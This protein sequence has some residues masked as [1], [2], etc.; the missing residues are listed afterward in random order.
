[1]PTYDYRCTKC[2]HTFEAFQSMKDEPVSACPVCG[3]PV[4]RM[5]GTGIGLIF[6]GSGFYQTDYKNKESGKAAD[7]KKKD[8]GKDSGATAE[9]K[10]SGESKTGDGA[11]PKGAAE[12]KKE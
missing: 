7:R 6:K 8:T 2:Q 12:N 4:K 5:I 3:A 9:T 10:P 11:K 1:M